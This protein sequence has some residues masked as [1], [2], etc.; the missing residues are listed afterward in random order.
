[1]QTRPVHYLT[2]IRKIHILRDK[3]TEKK[4]NERDWVKERHEEREK[5]R[6]RKKE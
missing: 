4:R 3:Q 6:K 2:T 5:E 1:M